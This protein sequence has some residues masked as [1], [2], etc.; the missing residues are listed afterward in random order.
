MVTFSLAKIP[1]C[2]EIKHYDFLIEN[3]AATPRRSEAV[4]M[5]F[6]KKGSNINVS[7]YTAQ[8]SDHYGRGRH[9]NFELYE[10]TEL[11]AINLGSDVSFNA[12][13]RW[14]ILNVQTDGAQ[15]Q[16]DTYWYIEDQGG[17]CEMSFVQGIK[18]FSYSIIELDITP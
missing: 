16:R 15:G 1:P 10:S 2:R 11:K 4:E 18:P 12:D 13:S 8:S 9:V 3:L 14:F 17:H 6:D 5:F 7:K